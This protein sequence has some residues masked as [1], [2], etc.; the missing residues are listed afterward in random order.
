MPKYFFLA[1]LLLTIACGKSQSDS[2]AV[3]QPQ[4]TPVAVQ[5]DNC[6]CPENN[7]AGMTADTI[8]KLNKKSIALCGYRNESIL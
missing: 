7:N 1:F 2:V 5:Q 4:T 3:I 8:F 6:R